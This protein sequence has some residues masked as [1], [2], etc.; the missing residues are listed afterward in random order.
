MID[1]S[2]AHTSSSLSP[3][4]SSLMEG[5]LLSPLALFLNQIKIARELHISV[6]TD[7]F[8]LFLNCKTEK[9]V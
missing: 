6:I 9:L 8:V 3:P 5:S 7:I 2:R 1:R 4:P